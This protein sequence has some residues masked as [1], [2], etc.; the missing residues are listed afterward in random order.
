MFTQMAGSKS[1]RTLL[2]LAARQQG[3][4]TYDFYVI[5]YLDSS[6][7]TQIAYKLYLYFHTPAKGSKSPRTLLFL[8]ARQQDLRFLCYC[9]L[10]FFLA[11][12][13]QDLRF[14]CYCIFR[15]CQCLRK[16]RAASPRVH[17]YS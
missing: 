2:F 13:Q 10:R 4:K 8:A 14:L 9:I 7:F 3:S 6:H 12:R 17:Y 1:P 16:W 11:A 15:D 5:V